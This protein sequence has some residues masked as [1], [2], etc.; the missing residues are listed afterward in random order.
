[1]TG[2]VDPLTLRPTQV[3]A[4]LLEL[5]RAT[6]RPAQEVYTLYVL[7]RALDRLSRTTYA[8]EFVLKGGI[9]LAAHNLRRPTSD[10][11]MQA[12]AFPLDEAH[13]R[14]VMT[15]IA[16]ADVPDGLVFDVPAMTMEQIRDD[17]EYTGMR[18]S[19]PVKLDRI[20]MK[21]KMDI[22]TGDP[23]TPAPESVRLP[24]LLGGH[25]DLIGHPL[26]TVLAEKTVTVLQR[27]TQ[28]TRWR[29]L[30]DVR[31]LARRYPFRAGDLLEAATAVAKHRE[32]QLGPLAPAFD[33]YGLLG[34][35]KWAAWVT[36]YGL[37]DEVEADL[38]AQA[39]AVAVFVD[40][41]YSGVVG[42]DARWDP[43]QLR[44]VI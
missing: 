21:L 29:D 27:G 2:P 5:S 37:Q 10:I 8:S 13:M 4:R 7:E 11:D 19:T 40:P 33:G 31:G 25:V 16:A 18:V 36:T 44:W 23:I 6:G 1:M 43:M 12:L 30:V 41:V 15:A 22:S 32:V 39:A 17:D 3:L 38:D 9:L 34:Q 42:P 35:R 28:S 24:G 26:P 20:A 14:Q